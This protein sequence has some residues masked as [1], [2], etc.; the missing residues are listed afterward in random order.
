MTGKSILVASNDDVTIARLRDPLKR[1]GYEV[2]LIS[3]GDSALESIRRIHPQ[4]VVADLTLS[5][6]DG[7]G[8]C[9]SLRNRAKMRHIPIFILASAQD[10]EVELNS[11]RSGAD[12][13]FVKPVPVREFL[14]R[15]EVMVSRIQHV[16]QNI[17]GKNCVFDGEL[18]EFMMLELIQWLHN[19]NKSGRLW[20][21]NLYERGS[22]YFD[23]GKIIMA[24]LDSLEGEEAIYRMFGWMAGRFEFEVGE[25]FVRRNIK[26]STIEIL[27]ECS[28]QMDEQHIY[29]QPTL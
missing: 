16:G 24:R 29:P 5:G 11:Y 15:L 28:K 2:N 17:P 20:L 12:G 22:I 14:I 3:D 1:S 9:W 26:K 10:K 4:A 19:N 23:E 6:L 21:S 18:G 27:L 8:L 25:Q 7:M 13:F